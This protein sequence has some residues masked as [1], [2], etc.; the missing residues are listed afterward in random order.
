MLLIEKLCGGRLPKLVMF[1]LD[2]TLIDSVP[3]LAAATDRMLAE[4]GRPPAGEARVR[5]WVGNGVVMLVRRAL[6]GRLSG[7]AVEAISEAD[8]A[9][10]LADFLRF[11]GEQCSDLTRVY[12]GV[13]ECLA[14]CREAGLE[15]A[16]VTN[17]SA[18]FIAPILSGLG[19]E[20]GFGLLLGGDQ[21]THKKP[22]PEALDYCLQHF[23]VA[24]QQALMVGDSKND[25]GAAK[26]AGVPVVAVP[27]GYNHG[28]PI[29]DAN[30]D[31]V[32]QDLRALWSP[33]G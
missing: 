15:M 25:V 32:V 31:L 8:M 28:E 11:Y 29:A 26:A 4:L 9:Q 24:P 13:R 5:D 7:P 22:H 1:D 17:K 2:G 12:D 18:Q 21:L 16:L 14:S 30:P 27:Y 10:P 23:G 20:Q 33:V 6:A 3:D 19:I